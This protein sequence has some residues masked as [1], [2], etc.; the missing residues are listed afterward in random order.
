M[1]YPSK[2]YQKQS[3]GLSGFEIMTFIK[4][5]HDEHLSNVSVVERRSIIPL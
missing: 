2:F 5:P 1:I 4:C 3:N